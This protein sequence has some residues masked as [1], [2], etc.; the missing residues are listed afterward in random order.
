MKIDPSTN[1][2]GR[3]FVRGSFIVSYY[4]GSGPLLDGA[5]RGA[6]H[7]RIDRSR[8]EIEP[9]DRFPSPFITVTLGNSPTLGST[10]FSN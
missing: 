7:H 8:G 1:P 3:G 9:V 6:T 2:S 5:A 4:A 10:R